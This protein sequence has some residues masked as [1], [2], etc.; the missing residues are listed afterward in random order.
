MWIGEPAD[1]SNESIPDTG[2]ATAIILG[3]ICLSIVVMPSDCAAD[4]RSDHEVHEGRRQTSRESAHAGSRL[5]LKNEL[6]R[7]RLKGQPSSRTGENPPYGSGSSKNWCVQQETSLPGHHPA[8]RRS[9]I[10]RVES[11]PSA[12]ARPTGRTPPGDDVHRPLQQRLSLLHLRRTE[13]DNELHGS[14][15]WRHGLFHLRRA[16]PDDDLHRSRQ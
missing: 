11:P 14:R 4:H 1:R 7:P 6:G 5:T 15:Q 12:P 3:S 8:G 10:A 9:G 16:E 2:S 13:G